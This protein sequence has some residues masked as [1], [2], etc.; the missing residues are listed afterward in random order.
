MEDQGFAAAA[1]AM[2]FRLWLAEHGQRQPK[3]SDRVEFLKLVRE[4]S[5]ALRGRQTAPKYDMSKLLD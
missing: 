4:C 1:S 2:A 5:M 3:A